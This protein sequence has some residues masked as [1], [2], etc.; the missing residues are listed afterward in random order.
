MPSLLLVAAA[1]GAYKHNIKKREQKAR[2]LQSQTTDE[3][4]EEGVEE[5]DIVAPIISL[6]NKTILELLASEQ[7]FGVYQAAPISTV[8]FCDGNVAHASQRIGDRLVQVLEKNPWVTGWI[9]RHSEPVDPEEK[10]EQQQRQPQRDETEEQV[11]TVL[12]EEKN[13]EQLNQEN[14]EPSEDDTANKVVTIVTET[15]NKPPA[16]TANE[17][18]ETPIHAAA[19]A[20][21]VTPTPTP[22]LKLCFDPTGQDVNTGHFKLF[23]PGDIDLCRDTTP[24]H[25]FAALFEPYNVLVER[26]D[27]LWG[28]DETHH[29][30]STTAST[31]MSQTPQQPQVLPRTNKAIFKLSLIPDAEQPDKRFAVVLSLSHL[32][33]DACTY[34]QLLDMLLNPNAELVA[35]NPIRRTDFRKAVSHLDPTSKDTASAEITN[36]LQNN[37]ALL[38][39]PSLWNWGRQKWTQEVD[40][41]ELRI[42]SVSNDFAQR[43]KNSDSGRVEPDMPGEHESLDQTAESPDSSSNDSMDDLTAPQQQGTATTLSETCGTASTTPTTS[44]ISTNSVLTS[45]FF[46]STSATVG[47]MVCNMRRSQLHECPLSELDAGN[48]TQ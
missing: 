7:E 36:N 2:K 47:F 37:V 6:H 28:D 23:Y 10:Q 14:V 30:A 25:D 3:T 24:Y 9:I 40:P 26:N 33:G 34:Y 12:S 46:Q 21:I 4:L 11:E 16:T 42:F 13:Q 27:C 18:T 17:T 1:Y 35:L 48:Y 44:K 41:S 38:S 5:C 43:E 19:A 15:Q 31:T 29:D 22:K 20:A 8:T 32:A 45:H 39:K